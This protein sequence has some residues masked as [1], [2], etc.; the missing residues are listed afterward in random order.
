MLSH[1]T[2][3]TTSRRMPRM[4]RDFLLGLT[5][6]TVVAMTGLAS[7]PT[8]SGLLSNPAHARFYQVEPAAQQPL[9]IIAGGGTK[10]AAPHALA[11][12]LMAVSSLALA[13]AT[14]FAFNLWM[15]RHLRLVHGADRRRRRQLA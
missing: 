10:R 4:L 2:S 1:A 15:A 12:Q 13:F 9:A 7:A 3:S 14:V 5:L 8:G 6:F 11:R